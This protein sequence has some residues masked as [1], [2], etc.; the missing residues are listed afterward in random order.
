[1]L[2]LHGFASSNYHNIVKLVLIEKGLQFE[3]I[4][5]YPPADEAYR[6]K[7]PTGK[8]PCLETEDGS[9]LAESKV[10]LNYLEDAYPEVPL[11]PANPFGRARVRELMEIVDLYLELPAR[12]LYPQALFDGKV[13]DE[14]KNTVRSELDRGVAGLRGRARFEPYIAGPELTLADF[15]AA[16]H[17][18]L[19]SITTKA[20]YGEDL[21]AAL[22][23][24]KRHR[25]MMGERESLKRV[26]ADRRDDVPK[27]ARHRASDPRHLGS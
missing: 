13:S 12:R 10:I 26:K 2:R 8:Y 3:E 16:I 5:T 1:M 15:G 4:T 23:A 14:V 7:N 25:E 22:P 18:P 20:I 9:L 24:V 19:I 6:S 27:F 11:L 21:L 17:L